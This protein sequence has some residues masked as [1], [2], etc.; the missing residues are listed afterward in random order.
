V[1]ASRSSSA[2]CCPV[3]AWPVQPR[4]RARWDYTCTCPSGSRTIPGEVKAFAKQI[5]RALSASRPDAVVAEAHKSRRAGKVCVDWLQNDP[6]RQTVAPYSLRG[7]PVPTVAA[8]LTWD[9]VENAVAMG[10]A[11]GLTF[12]YSDV[13]DRSER[14]GDLFAPLLAVT[15]TLHD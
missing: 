13:L 11:A 15:Q 5:G 9:E 3:S 1:R 7:V 4:R 12:L 10:D 2:S 8:P 6:T 14:Y